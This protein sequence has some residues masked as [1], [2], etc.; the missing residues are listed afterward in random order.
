MIFLCC[1][2]WELLTLSCLSLNSPI[3]QLSGSIVKHKTCNLVL[4]KY[5]SALFVCFQTIFLPIT[6]VISVL[7]TLSSAAPPTLYASSTLLSRSNGANPSDVLHHRE[8]WSQAACRAQGSTLLHF[9]TD[10]LVF[11]VTRFLPPPQWITPDGS[12]A[13]NRTNKRRKQK[14]NLGN[15]ES[16][17][18]PIRKHSRV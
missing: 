1:V 11:T 2:S 7:Q 8:Q 14:V 6:S 16:S 5:L 3:L 18:G 15:A 4:C 12:G 9:A 17:G 13:G 10:R